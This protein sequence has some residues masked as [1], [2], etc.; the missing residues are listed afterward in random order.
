MLTF[1]SQL[2]QKNLSWMNWWI[3]Y[4]REALEC[5]G[6]CRTFLNVSEPAGSTPVGVEELQYTDFEV[7]A[8]VGHISRSTR[9]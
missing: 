7:E 6:L 9:G 8:R 3:T 5:S 1:P 4:K 2:S